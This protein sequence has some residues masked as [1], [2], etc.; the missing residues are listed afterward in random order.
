MLQQILKD[1]AESK[2]T[3]AK[4]YHLLG[5]LVNNNSLKKGVEVGVAYG[6]QSSYLMENTTLDKLIGVDAYAAYDTYVDPMKKNQ[7]YHDELYKYVSEK[8]SKYG[9]KYQLVRGFSN[10][11]GEK[12]PD[13][14]DFV[15]LDGDHGYFGV[16]SD[17]KFWWPK[18]KQGGF[19]CGDD[20]GHGSFPGVKKAITQFF[21][22]L[23]MAV[24][25]STDGFWFLQKK[26]FND[27]V[28][29]Y[30]PAYNAEKTIAAAI[31]S[32]MDGNFRKDD[33]LIIV[34][35]CSPDHTASILNE[36]KQKYPTE[37]NIIHHPQNLGGGAARNTAIR[38]AKNL[39]VFNLDSDNVLIKGSVDRLRERIVIGD[40]DATCFE[41]TEFYFADSG[42]VSHDTKYPYQEYSIK[43]Y[44]SS[45]NVP[46]AGGNYL[47]FKDCWRKSGEFSNNLGAL[48]TYTFG[49]K[50]IMNGYTYSVVPDVFYRHGF[51]NESYWVTASVNSSFKALSVI[52]P[53]L[54]GFEM[55]TQE[56]LLSKKGRYH[57]IGL[58]DKI[59]LRVKPDFFESSQ[60]G[61][62]ESSF[63]RF[64][65]NKFIRSFY[66]MLPEQCKKVFRGK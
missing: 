22:R 39:L 43:N 61:K 9:D 3:W 44:F 27:A 58:L 18:V 41:G 15:Y 6:G 34:N 16:L 51:G 36:Y 26:L 53:F 17:L 31:D 50:F 20:Y 56:Y 2:N 4:S 10:Q 11:V 62:F 46:G 13:Y 37:I 23:D 1:E 24:T 28:S 64:R 60:S 35:D 14:Q 7:K 8:L 59:P 25:V 29:F 52:M 33:E 40:C 12:I 30:I 48:D 5:E 63:H 21:D 66:N 32:I 38:A 54:H 47:F 45:P 42:K 19:L 55:K 49:L 57:W 65:E